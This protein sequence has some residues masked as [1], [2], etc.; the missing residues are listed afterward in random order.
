[1]QRKYLRGFT[2]IEMMVVLTIIGILCFMAL[3]SP[4]AGLTRKQ[5]IESLELIED[6]KKLE[7]AEYKSLS[8]LPSDNKDLGIPKAELLI[9]NYVTKIEVEQ[10]VFNIYFGNKANLPIKDKILSIRPI[11]VKGSPVSPMS[12]ICGYSAVPD[13]MQA[14][15]DNKTSVEKKYLPMACR[16]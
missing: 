5:V 4:E 13:G 12:W 10:G 1:M 8:A 14:I 11:V 7:A 16:I 15:G 3:P 2:L 6:F 9:G